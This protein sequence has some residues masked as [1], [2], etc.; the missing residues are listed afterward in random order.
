M[1]VST[2]LISGID[3]KTMISELMKVEANPQTLLK[4]QLN[5]TR[6]DAAAYRA[7]NT[8]FEALRTAAAAL[9]D[10]TAWTTTKAS[11]SDTSVTA[12]AATGAATGSLSFTVTSLAATHSVYSSDSWPTADTALDPAGPTTLTIGGVGVTLTAGQTVNDAVKAINAS[13]A[14]VTAV[15]VDTG[16][17][18]RLQLTSK[19]SGAAG[20]F[21]VT[22]DVAVT[23]LTTGANATLRVGTAAQGYDVTS[24]TNT[25]TDVLPGTTFTVSKKDAAATV[26]VT[27]DPDATA[28]KVQSFVDAA[29]SLLSAV[30]SYT[31]AK[32]T[33][34]VLKG[35]STLRGLST[36]ILDVMSRA[37]GGKSAS[38]V[39][40]ELTRDGQLTFDKA[41]FTKALSSDPAAAQALL[42]DKKI[43]SAGTDGISG[44]ADDVT[45]PV[46]FAA[47]LEVLA[48]GASDSTNGSLVLLAKSGDSLAKDIEDR[49]AAWDIRLEMRKTTLTRQFTAME[50]ALSS[51]QNQ[52]AWL[53][54]QI[55]GL[56]SWSS[57]K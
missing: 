14:G 31:D 57:S 27:K 9:T 55:A 12:T 20:T 23:E 36:Q 39:G 7:V 15:A 8:R 29:N 24:S 10:A 21:T 17:G 50:T 16:A 42:T 46:G 2:G 11:S 37:V 53:S 43:V 51:M 22:G 40:I 30:S 56:P 33:S 28:A 38:T 35:D 5:A 52:A 6:S 25:F 54:S 49:I 4:Q 48:K 32:S 44:N 34:A 19:T 18:V 45:S 3:Y 1:S 13:A 26:T 47:Q 41:V